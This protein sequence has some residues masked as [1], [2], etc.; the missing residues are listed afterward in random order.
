MGGM[1]WHIQANLE[2]QT[3][4]RPGSLIYLKQK[5]KEIE[6]LKDDIPKLITILKEIGH[7]WCSTDPIY[8]QEETEIAYWKTRAQ[9]AELSNLDAKKFVGNHQAL[10]DQFEA[11]TND[12]AGYIQR[13]E[14]EM[15]HL[16]LAIKRD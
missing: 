15:K 10:I 3:R 16:W 4:D 7:S 1:I 8:T 9:I 6:V 14:T 11:K 2:I 13:L 12:F 5:H